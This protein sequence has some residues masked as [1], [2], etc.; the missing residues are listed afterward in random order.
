MYQIL[1]RSSRVLWVWALRWWWLLWSWNGLLYT[2]LMATSDIWLFYEQDIP[3][4]YERQRKECIKENMRTFKVHVYIYTLAVCMNYILC[5]AAIREQATVATPTSS[6]PQSCVKDMVNKMHVRV[7]YW[8]ERNPFLGQRPVHV[9]ITVIFY[10]QEE[11]EFNDNDP[12]VDATTTS[13]VKNELKVYM[14]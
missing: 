3:C 6:N 1:K 10:V 9:Y 4:Q 12:I 7:N 11:I 14:N 8:D 13:K 2:K 5:Q